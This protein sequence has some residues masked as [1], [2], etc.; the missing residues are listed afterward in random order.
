MVRPWNEDYDDI[1]LLHFLK[2]QKKKGFI[3][4]H[5]I[6]VDFNPVKRS[7]TELYEIVTKE[8]NDSKKK[9]ALSH[10]TFRDHLDK[11]VLGRMLRK[12][13]Q[14]R[15]QVYGLDRDTY[16][17]MKTNTLDLPP[18]ELNRRRLKIRYGLS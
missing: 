16:L 11:L 7:Y 4:K 12:F 8:R 18:E 13:P 15:R 10:E 17:E 6:P 1:I 5:D 2:E 14:G 3:T 9:K